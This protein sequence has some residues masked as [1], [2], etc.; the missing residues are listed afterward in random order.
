MAMQSNLIQTLSTIV[1]NN[2]NSGFDWKLL[3]AAIAAFGAVLSPIVYWIW[4]RRFAQIKQNTHEWQKL[5]RAPEVLFVQAHL[6]RS[7]DKLN[8]KRYPGHAGSSN[9]ATGFKVTVQINNPGDVPIHVLYTQLVLEGPLYTGWKTRKF[10]ANSDYGLI[11]PH[12]LK[13]FFL[14]AEDPHGEEQQD[15]WPGSRFIL[16]YVSG[17]QARKLSLHFAAPDVGPMT[18]PIPLDVLDTSSDDLLEPDSSL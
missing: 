6:E 7:I 10:S 5:Q 14:F 16:K 12:S 17:S 13:D 11:P 2:A 15:D 4:S 18:G 9:P 1:S 3:V 8:V